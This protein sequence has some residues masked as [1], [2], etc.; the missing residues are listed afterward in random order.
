[1]VLPKNESNDGRYV[2]LLVDVELNKPLIW[3][4][5]ICFEEEKRWV[6]FKYESLPLFCFY[7]GKL[8]HGEK[9]C[10]KT[11]SYQKE[12]KLEEE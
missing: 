12:G 11:L 1:M 6:S 4:T 3:G 9:S 5:R 2:K 7:C 8:C 10:G